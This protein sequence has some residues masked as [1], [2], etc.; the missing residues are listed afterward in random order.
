MI[1]VHT[2]I[3]AI[4]LEVCDRYAGRTDKVAYARKVQG[5]WLNTTHDELRDRVECFALGLLQSGISA[6]E[7]VGIVSENRIEWPI[8][9]FAISTIGAVDVP[10]FP[11]LTPK[12]EQY[13]YHNC[14]AAAII[15][16]NQ[17]QLNKILKVREEIPSLRLI[18]VM[19]DDV[20]LQPGVMSFSQ[21]EELGRASCAPEVRRRKFID[22]AKRVQTED[23]LTLIY[24]SGTTGNPKGVMLTHRN[25]TANIQGAVDMIELSDSDVL[26]SYLPLCHSYERMAGYYLAFT[27]GASTYFAESIESVSENLR[28]VRPTIMTSVPRLFERIRNRVVANVD[29]QPALRKKIF[30]WA[31]GVG[32][33]AVDARESGKG[34]S[35]LLSLQHTLADKLVFAKIRE[36]TGGRIR[37]FVSGGAA[38]SFEIG[39]FFKVIGLTIL[40]GYGLT[41][42]SPVITI[43]RLE[44]PELGTVGTPLKNLVVRIAGDGEILARGPSIMK[45][46]WADEE[47]TRA[48]IDADGWLH[49]GDIGMF[50]VHGHLKI[51]DR[52]KHIFVSS[53]GKN[54]VPG[55]I[56]AMIAESRFVDQVMLIGEAREY[57]TA[58]IVPD[59]DTVRSFYRDQKLTER[60]WAE[61]IADPSL[62]KAIERDVNTMQRDLSKYERVR[63]FTLLA[64]PF[65]VD[66][67]MLTPTLKVKRNVVAKHYSA[68][69]DSM[70]DEAESG[71]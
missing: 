15:V 21:I 54:I 19:N 47:A 49:T 40:E 37:F 2:T 28:E 9:D 36:R 1:P 55:P 67:G 18:I 11:T 31:I 50:N 24:T 6:G 12:Q 68:L 62:V 45:G 27:V 8:A 39:R 51:T 30:W 14:Q 5:A 70:Y 22:M 53:G 17:F 13:I 38:L 61:M 25:L 44:D 23:L 64:E 20:P 48:T 26:L 52:K 35:P 46:Y 3:P 65:S 63:R 33:R 59:E 69:I 71:D 7:R 10:I 58:L 42:T 41:E 43:N 16:S 4:F 29:T 57:C 56:E 66:N 32:E 60:P 34:L